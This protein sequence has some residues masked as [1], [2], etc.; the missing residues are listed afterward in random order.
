MNKTKDR[1]LSEKEVDRV[2][3]KIYNKF[4][5]TND[6]NDEVIYGAL[7]IILKNDRELFRQ[8]LKDEEMLGHIAKEISDTT[9]IELK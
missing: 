4:N 6:L 2:Y 9:G 3:A 8:A 1:P 7:D 5:I